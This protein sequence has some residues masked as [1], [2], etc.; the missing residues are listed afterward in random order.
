MKTNFAPLI[1][2]L[3][4]TL[5]GCASIVSQSQYPVTISST[6]PGATVVVRDSKSREMHKAQTPTTLT[7]PASAGY[8][9]KAR[10]TL[11][12][13]KEGHANAQTPLQAMIDPWYLGNIIFGGLIGMVFIDPLTGAMWELEE[14]ASA[15][16]SPLA[17][18]TAAPAPAGETPAA[19]MGLPE[20]PSVVDQLRTLKALRDE[21]VIS[22]EEYELKRAPL[23]DSL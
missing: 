5:P 20:K 18:N 16:L 22:A 7:L 14:S 17:G 23:L 12:F 15:T 10:Y 19:T 11:E 2:C 13:S 21:G 6:P 8:F 3:A 4:L 1:F 9:S